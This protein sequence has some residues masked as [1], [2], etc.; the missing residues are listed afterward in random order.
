MTKGRPVDPN[1]AKRGTGN[2]PAQGQKKAALVPLAPTTY[3]P[4]ATL[5]ESVHPA[6]EIAVAEMGGNR[7]LKPIDLEH[8]EVWCWAKYAFDDAAANVKK[9]GT[10]VTG[11]NGPMRNPSLQTMKDSAATMRQYSDMLGLNPGARIRLG[12]MEITGMSMLSTLNTSLDGK[13]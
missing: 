11:Q 2:R 7:H 6:W 3:Q 5:P 13:P 12:L 1:R 4:P 10:L 8:L 9:Y